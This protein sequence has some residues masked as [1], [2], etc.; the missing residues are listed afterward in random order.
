M[1]R[2]LAEDFSG[3]SHGTNISPVKRRHSPIS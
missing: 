3:R 1:S 2:D